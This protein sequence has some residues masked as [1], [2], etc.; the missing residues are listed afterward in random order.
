MR[1]FVDREQPRRRP[2][3]HLHEARGVDRI[4][5]GQIV[6]PGPAGAGHDAIVDIDDAVSVRPTLNDASVWDDRI[7]GGPP[8]RTCPRRSA[9]RATRLFPRRRHRVAS[10]KR[11]GSEVTTRARSSAVCSLRRRD[12]GRAYGRCLRLAG[13]GVAARRTSAPLAATGSSRWAWAPALERRWRGRWSARARSS[14]PVHM[15]AATLAFARKNPER[16]GCADDVVL[17]HG[18]GRLGFTAR[19]PMTGFASRRMRRRAAAARRATRATGAAH[20]AGAGTDAPATHAARRAAPAPNVRRRVAPDDGVRARP[21][22]DL[23]PQRQ[24]GVR[25]GARIEI[26]GRRVR[27]KW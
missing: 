12:A 4:G 2:V 3:R 22:H 11:V 5:V 17:V 26:A 6:N 9:S 24:P 25:H 20:R 15:D 10:L 1:S 27:L 7:C 23:Q 14:W 18:D 16:A 13:C 21:P 19:A 8:V